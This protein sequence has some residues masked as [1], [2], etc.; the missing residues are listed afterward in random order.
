MKNK[1]LLIGIIL[2]C[3]TLSSIAQRHFYHRVDVASS[4]IYSFVVSN[5]VTGYANYLSHDILF[6]NSFVY[7]LYSG[8][9][10][11]VKIKSKGYSPMGVTAKEI[12]N[13]AYAGIKLG[14]QSDLMGSFNWGVYASGHYRI[15]QADINFPVSE[16][17]GRECFQY[18]KPGLGLLFTFGGVE[19]NVK[20]QFETAV[21][22]DIPIGYKGYFG[23][24]T[25]VLQKGLSTHFSLKVA[26]F[27][28][29]SAGIFGDFAHYKTFKNMADN[30]NFRPYS[31]GLTFTITPKRGEDLFQ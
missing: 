6:D 17:Y 23:T 28:W 19:N 4:N 21:R 15:N 11:D 25:D 5:L 29:L 2:M 30:D 1:K 26:G 16:D 8:E 18:V 7:T 3:N 10:D 22:Y 20:V 12:F 13:D 24:S 14:Y 9:I 31:F 27:S